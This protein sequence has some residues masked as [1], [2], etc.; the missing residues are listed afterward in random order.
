MRLSFLC[1]CLALM[2]MACTYEERKCEFVSQAKAPVELLDFR[3]T[4]QLSDTLV[5]IQNYFPS[6]QN[7]RVIVFPADAD[8]SWQLRIG[9]GRYT[10]T[11]NT[12]YEL[13]AETG[14]AEAIGSNSGWKITPVRE[15]NAFRVKLR[16]KMNEAGSYNIYLSDMTATEDNLI[17]AGKYRNCEEKVELIPIFSQL[18][19]SVDYQRNFIFYVAP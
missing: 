10:S 19:G 15:G 17:P 11:S 2:L 16:L 12:R 4:Y 9:D 7:G 1:F 3:E 18:P 5:L 6:R 8:L 13:L 14:S